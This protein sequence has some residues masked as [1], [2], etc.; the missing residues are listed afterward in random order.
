M[1]D[2]AR[3]AAA[4]PNNA[5][6]FRSHDLNLPGEPAR[7][8]ICT[9]EQWQRCVTDRVPPREGVA[10]VGLDAGGSA[11]MTSAT[12]AFPSTG[13]VESYAAFAGDPD[14]LTRGRNDGVG[15]RYQLLHDAGELMVYP[16]RST[17][18]VDF[19]RDLADGLEG[20]R[21]VACG[22]DRYRRAEVEDALSDANLRWP[23]VLRGQG[24]S[25]TADGSA[26]VRSAQRVILDASISCVVGKGLMV[27]AISESAIRRD[28]L[29]NPSL[30]KSRKR[31]RIDALSAFVIAAG[32]TERHRARTRA[33]PR[34]W[35]VT[36][37]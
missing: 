1:I 33:Q 27:H 26:D 14:L 35:R 17:P 7:E 16:G 31:G 18:V 36:V 3:L 24:S 37:T 32:L 25:A 19:L 34:P 12:V 23:L 20:F 13:R 11:S 22:A 28:A 8:M 4:N 29:G 2:T 10:V 5:P 30:E 6:D 21:V 15:R 9:P